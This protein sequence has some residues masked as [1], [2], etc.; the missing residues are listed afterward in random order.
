MILKIDCLDINYDEN[1]SLIS[2]NFNNQQ[3]IN[4]KV[5]CIDQMGFESY[6]PNKLI[7][8]PLDRHE[9]SV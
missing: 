2:L 6:N 1:I 9:L 4:L 5:K 3:D 8:I 7:L